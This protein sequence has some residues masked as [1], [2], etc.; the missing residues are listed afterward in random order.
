MPLDASPEK[1]VQ[2]NIIQFPIPEENRSV[3]SEPQPGTDAFTIQLLQ[4]KG[5]SNI[6]E[7]R[8]ALDEKRKEREQ[9]LSKMTNRIKHALNIG[10]TKAITDLESEIT[11]LASLI[12]KVPFNS[13]FNDEHASAY[14]KAA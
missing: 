10:D 12:K 11:Q 4:E 6:G 5:F 14:D 1:N 13:S 3:E 8:A 7:A 9:L 2:D